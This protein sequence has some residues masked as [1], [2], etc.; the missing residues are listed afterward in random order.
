M[1]CFRR[2]KGSFKARGR[3]S[4]LGSARPAARARETRLAVAAATDESGKFQARQVWHDRR[5]L[6]QTFGA[7]VDWHLDR[8][9]SAQPV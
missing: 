4:A 1:W 3:P 5:R 8:P 6:Y 9:L 7:A 2:F